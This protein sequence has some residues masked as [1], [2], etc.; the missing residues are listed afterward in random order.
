M[1]DFLCKLWPYLAGGLIGW[2]LA[3]W[4]A[5]KLK[6]SEPPEEK[7]V[8]KQIDNPQHLALISKLESE[9]KEIVGLRTKLSGMESASAKTVDNPAHL[10][11]I[12]E[13][14]TQVNSFKSTSNTTAQTALSGATKTVDNPVHI[15][16]ISELEAQ[17]NSLKSSS[18]TAQTAVSGSTK[19]IDN[20]EHLKRIKELESQVNVLQQGPKI[21]LMAAKAAGFRL[22]NDND[23]TAIEGI[24][25][26]INDLIQADGVTSFRQLADTP[27]SSIQTVLDKAGSSYKIANPGTWPDQANLAANNSWPALRALQDVLVGGVYPDASAKPIK[28]SATKNKPATVKKV[29]TAKKEVTAVTVD[30]AAAKTAGFRVKNKEGRD[31]FTVI[32]GIGPK[33]NDLIHDAGIH[34]YSE[35]GRTLVENI[36]EILDD[37]G[38]RYTLAKPGTW[39]AQADMAAANKW[40]ALKAW[41]DELDG[42]K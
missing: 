14:E 20:P 15:K 6:Y 22:K 19:T 4:F 12:S 9:N 18:N 27:V 21:D 16:R 1:I 5:R 34:T 17:I 33:I 25:P 24:G 37:A 7:I 41:Q 35:L 28:S 36:Q 23:L 42:G 31:D 40:E 11:R 13:L 3:G 32:E 8:E 26:K 39:P 29:S 38:P 10:K 2:L 30:K